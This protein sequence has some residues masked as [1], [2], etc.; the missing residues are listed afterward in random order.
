MRW[1]SGTLPTDRQFTDQRRETALGDIYDYRA[2]MYSSYLNRWIQPDTIIPD[3]AN[4][5][6]F[7][8]YS[9]VYNRPVNLLDPSGHVAIPAFDPGVGGKGTE[10]DD[11]GISELS[12][13]EELY[14]AFQAGYNPFADPEYM[15]AEN[16][17]N[18]PIFA[19]YYLWAL[20]NDAWL[21]LHLRDRGDW[22]KYWAYVTTGKHGDGMS[23]GQMA[24]QMA[25]DPGFAVPV[26][27]G[28]IQ[29]VGG[30]S[31]GGSQIW[32]PGKEGDPV[33][34]AYEHWKKHRSEFPE[35]E[36]AKQYVEG[37]HSFVTNPPAG[38]LVKVRPNGDVLFYHAALID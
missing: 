28:I 33:K 22:F 18:H 15:L 13:S 19:D 16:R 20:G 36:N 35:Y 8:R 23:L 5:Q 6:S 7:N 2:R 14:A 26:V 38:T 1:E 29:M 32:T 34:N 9:Y 10:K 21:P 3:P 30:N 37:S 25:T 4:P 11:F 24:A 27:I 31:G 12:N 17:M